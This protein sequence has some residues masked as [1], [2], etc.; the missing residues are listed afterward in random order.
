L[1]HF[2]YIVLGFRLFSDTAQ[3]PEGPWFDFSLPGTM[4]T[5]DFETTT[6]KPEIEGY[7]WAK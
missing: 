7:Y 4:T 6:A 5:A 1:G 2:V 3:R